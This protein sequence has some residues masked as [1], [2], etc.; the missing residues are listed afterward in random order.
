MIQR[1]VRGTQPG[2]ETRIETQIRTVPQNRRD[3]SSNLTSGPEENGGDR[4]P[5]HS[6][7][8]FPEG[9]QLSLN[10]VSRPV[11]VNH[12]YAGEPL[13]P[14]MN[15]RYIRLDECDV[16]SESVV[17]IQQSQGLNREFTEHSR[18]SLVIQHPTTNVTNTRALTLE[19]L[20]E[21]NSRFHSKFKEQSRNSLKDPVQER[22]E[23]LQHNKYHQNGVHSKFRE[24]SQHLMGTLNVSRSRV[25]AASCVDPQQISLTGYEQHPQE[26]QTYPVVREPVN[27][28]P[29][30]TNNNSA[31]LDLPNVQMDLPAPLMPQQV[32]Q[33]VTEDRDEVTENT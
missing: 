4:L 22:S 21:R 15:K 33:P 17:G 11:F 16:S 27:V 7:K 32:N 25:Q 13:V 1:P 26:I 23:H 29:M 6:G 12:Y 31:L 18:E 9:Y 3:D 8:S 10:D 28:Q 5:S 2:K 24:V 19:H 30:T 20:Q 14:V